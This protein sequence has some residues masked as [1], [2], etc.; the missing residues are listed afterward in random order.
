VFIN[1]GATKDKKLIPANS[2][3]VPELQTGLYGSYEHFFGRISIPIQLGVYVYNKGD[4][5][6]IF[7][8]MGFR[9]KI[10]SHFNTELMLKAHMGKA[11]LIHTG[12]GYTL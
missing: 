6:F 7:Q 4:N 5:P 3:A 10:N 9:C 2:Q 8:Q 11:D 1:P 12:I